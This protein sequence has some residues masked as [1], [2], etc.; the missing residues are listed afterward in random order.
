VNAIVVLDTGGRV[1]HGNPAAQD[2]FADPAMNAA[3]VHIDVLLPDS[4]AGMHVLLSASCPHISRRVMINGRPMLLNASVFFQGS[5]CAGILCLF[6]DTS[7]Y[8]H[9]ISRLKHYKE[10]NDELDVIINSS[11]DGLWICDNQARVLR[12]NPASQKM[13]GV[14]EA[15]VIGRP[16]QELIDEGLFDQS[17]TL[18]VLEKETAVTLNQRLKDGRRILVTGNP[19]YD[20]NGG[21]RLVVVNARDISELNRLHAEL[22]KSRALTHQFRSELSHFHRIQNLGSRFIMRSP[23]MQRAFETAMRVAPVDSSVL[24]TGESGVGKGLIS[25]LIHEA[26]RRRKGPLIRINCGAIPE[27]LIE[28]ELFGYEKGAFTGALVEGKAGYFEM[29]EG[30]TLFWDE[31]G[32]LPL[33]VQVKLLRFLESNEVTRVGA[34]RPQKIDVRIIAATNRNLEQMVDSGRFRKDL[35]FRLNVVPI[36]IPPLHRRV[37]DIPAL[38]LFFLDHFNRKYQRKK[39]VLPEAVDCLCRYSYPGNVRELQNL[40]ERLVVLT[41]EDQIAQLHLPEKVRIAEEGDAAF[42]ADEKYDLKSA[43]QGIEKRLITRALDSAVS[44]RQAAVRLGIDHTT[45]SRKI[46]R[47]KIQTGSRVF[48]SRD[49]V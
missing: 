30:G 10:V 5:S 23:V 35:F 20:E 32:E 41:P 39:I 48:Q 6:Q 2:L 25:E 27:S 11:F 1:V 4:W 17:A 37:D 3:G 38:I 45:L 19:I 8:E 29:A 33:S 22:Q 13:S 31:I 15:D 40:V 44:Q 24:L 7:A 28:S 34:T 46:R 42:A 21:I 47:Y 16:M 26:S 12:V 49:P 36:A 43:V 9:T 14:T 18:A